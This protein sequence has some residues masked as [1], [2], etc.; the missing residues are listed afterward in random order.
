VIEQECF[1]ITGGTIGGRAVVVLREWWRVRVVSERTRGAHSV[2]VQSTAHHRS[3]VC[4]A[5][6][7]VRSVLH[8]HGTCNDIYIYIY[9]ILNQAESRWCG[10]CEIRILSLLCSYI[11]KH[12]SRLQRYDESKETAAHP[13]RSVEM[14]IT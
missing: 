14:K 11:V 5:T 13:E 1:V 12:I 8:S 6:I 9:R 3:V 7:H 10:K 4:H 2:S